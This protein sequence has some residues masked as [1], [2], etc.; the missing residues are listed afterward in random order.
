MRDDLYIRFLPFP[1]RAVR[2][3]VMPNDSGSY[4]ILV[5]TLYPEEIQRRALEHELEHLRLDHLSRGESAF[6]LEAEARGEETGWRSICCYTPAGPLEEFIPAGSRADFAMV[7]PSRGMRPH[8]RQGQ[9]LFC[10]AREPRWDGDAAVFLLNGRAELRQAYR[11]AFGGAYL[12]NAN[13]ACAGEDLSYPAG[14]E[15]PPLLGT[16]MR[17]RRLPPVI[18]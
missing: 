15:L 1:N 13:R 4:D 10:R 3:A 17:R 8:Y 18:L 9:H 6:L 5:N 7:V 16:P 2:A 12:L 11:D 14:E